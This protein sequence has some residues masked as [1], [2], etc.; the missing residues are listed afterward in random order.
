MSS[1]QIVSA[2]AL[3][4]GPGS[5]T[6]GTGRSVLP[7]ALY[8]HMSPLGMHYPA[9]SSSGAGQSLQVMSSVCTGLRFGVLELTLVNVVCIVVLAWSV[10]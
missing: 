4:P 9:Y 7:S 3:Q 8:P 6:T 1:A 5:G 2:T 10:S